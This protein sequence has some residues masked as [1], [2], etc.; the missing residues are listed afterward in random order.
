[1][2]SASWTETFVDKIPRPTPAHL[3]VTGPAQ[4][5]TPHGRRSGIPPRR[6]APLPTDHQSRALAVRPAPAGSVI[7]SS[8]SRTGLRRH[9]AV[10]PSAA[11]AL[12]PPPDSWS[13]APLFPLT[14]GRHSGR[15]STRTTR[16]N[17]PADVSVRHH[18]DARVETRRTRGALKTGVLSPTEIGRGPANS[19]RPPSTS[20]RFPEQL[21][22]RC[23]VKAVE[24]ISG[25]P[26]AYP[27]GKISHER[28]NPPTLIAPTERWTHSF[29]STR[30]SRSTTSL[31]GPQ[32]LPV[33]GPAPITRA[34]SLPG[35]G[36]TASSS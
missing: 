3:G 20:A 18:F 10:L 13:A 22:H 31:A 15:P 8:C 17:Q 1:M 34:T 12:G 36:S 30:C 5:R 16:F 19:G 2:P 26:E 32:G 29:P 23:Q 27:T 9:P 14:H 21:L 7:R 25:D 6:G 24:V 35:S 28:P 33:D 11:D 4:P